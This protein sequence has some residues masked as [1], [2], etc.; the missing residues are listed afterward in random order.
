MFVDATS[1]S[2]TVTLPTATT[3][4]GKHYIIIRID[5]SGNTVSVARSSTD[6]INGQTSISLASN[7]GLTVASDGTSKW[8][9]DVPPATE[10]PSGIAKSKISTTGTF[11]LADLPATVL[12]NTQDNDLGAH[13]VQISEISAPGTPAADKGRIFLNSSTNKL[14]IKKDDGTSVSLEEQGGG[15]ADWI[16]QSKSA[17]YTALWGEAVLVTTGASTITITLTTASGNSGKKVLVKKVDS[18][19]GTVIIDGAGSET[20][21][22]VLTITLTGQY[23]RTELF[24]NGTNIEV[25]V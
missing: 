24:S 6:T 23:A 17:N 14:S 16:V 22:G 8:A 13:Y 12:N 1:G 5:S 7:T 11:V 18:G 15:S 9:F 3:R 19:S 10:L 4:K 21:D 20:I 2:V 25:D